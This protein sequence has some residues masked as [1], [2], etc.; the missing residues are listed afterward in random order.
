MIFVRQLE[1]NGPEHP[2]PLVGDLISGNIHVE[3]Y[4]VNVRVKRT[5]LEFRFTAL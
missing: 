2:L 5:T 4:T 1:R 3:A